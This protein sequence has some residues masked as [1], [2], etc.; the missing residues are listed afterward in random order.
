MIQN[1]FRCKVGGDFNLYT[2]CTGDTVCRVR[3]KTSVNRNRK[4]VFKNLTTQDLQIF[5]NGS[6]GKKSIFL[7]SRQSNASVDVWSYQSGDQGRGIVVQ[8][9]ISVYIKRRTVF[10]EKSLIQYCVFF[11]ISAVIRQDH[12]ICRV[13]VLQELQN[14]FQIL[15]MEKNS[16]TGKADLFLQKAPAADPE[17]PEALG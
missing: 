1:L 6:G 13:F 14:E 11:H 3:E 15:V 17:G 9:Q 4:A 8:S 5:V 16:L 10:L 12:K 2:V 7:F